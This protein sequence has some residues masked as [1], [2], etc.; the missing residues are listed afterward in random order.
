MFVM[1]A[2]IH[3]AY[4]LALTVGA[5][6]DGHGT[7]HR[8]YHLEVVRRQ[9]GGTARAAAQRQPQRRV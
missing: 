8:G 4:L 7:I 3:A 6:A 5:G 2:T 1:D 9:L